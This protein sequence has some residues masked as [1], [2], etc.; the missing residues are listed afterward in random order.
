MVSLGSLK[1]RWLNKRSQRP[2]SLQCVA[3][4]ATKSSMVPLFHDMMDKK[5]E[6]YDDDMIEKYQ[7]GEDHLVNV[8][9]L[10]ERISKFKLRL[11]QT[12][13]TF[14]VIYGK[15]LGFIV[16]KRG[17]KVEP[18]KVKEIMYLPSPSIIKE[19]ITLLR[20]LNYIAKFITNLTDKYQ[21]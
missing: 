3:L 18:G 13:C 6:V 15:L 17:I 14:G 20:K 5:I 21:Q 10:F 2:H 12:K 11:N 8:C 1:L 7:E 9:M 19:V 16:S 4:S